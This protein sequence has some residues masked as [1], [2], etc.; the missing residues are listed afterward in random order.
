MARLQ[1]E[2]PLYAAI[3][4][5]RPVAAEQLPLADDELLLAYALG[6]EASYLFVVRKGGVQR[7]LRDADPKTMRLVADTIRAKIGREPREDDAIFLGAYYRQLRAR[8]ER[9]LLFGKRR[10]NKYEAADA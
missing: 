9:D 8:M 2:Y 3:T 7:V 5:P 4:Y 10:A 1:R 6:E